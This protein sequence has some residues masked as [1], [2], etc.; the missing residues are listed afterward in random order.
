MNCLRCGSDIGEALGLCGSCQSGGRPAGGSPGPHA[1]HL[2]P[3]V[4]APT[5]AAFSI[6]IL[7]VLL[8]AA[9]FLQS[10]AFYYWLKGT[11]QQT[12]NEAS[13]LR[14][15]LGRP[16]SFSGVVFDAGEMP[17]DLQQAGFG[18][19][20]MLMEKGPY[21]EFGRRFANSNACP[22]EYLKEYL[23][24]LT[25]VSSLAELKMAPSLLKGREV[26]LAGYRT[27]IESGMLKGMP[28][29]FGAG[30]EH[31]VYVSEIVLGARLE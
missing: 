10:D 2:V 13:S 29:S 7:L 26:R 11:P 16:F 6:S 19:P 12:G 31:L 4:T 1:H 9:V 28:F 14:I 18:V 8:A 3:L 30:R 20:L 23:T 5:I 25:P 15:T 21:L 27:R 17:A 24:I 22:T